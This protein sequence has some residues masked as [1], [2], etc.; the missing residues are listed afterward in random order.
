MKK[1]IV[2]VIIPVFN[3]EDSIAKCVDSVLNQNLLNYVILINDGSQDS[4]KI[5]LT[6]YQKKYEQIKLINLEYNKGLVN[7]LNIGIE[8]STAPFLARLDADDSM[9]PNRL[10]KQYNFLIKNN[11]DLIGGQIIG[12]QSG[13]VYKTYSGKRKNINKVDLFFSSC[14]FHPT[15]F[16]KSEVFNL[17]YQT[18]MP[19]EDVDFLYR[20]VQNGYRLRN[21][22]EPVTIWNETDERK[23]TITNKYSH[24]CLAY[25]IRLNYIFYKRVKVTNSRLLE[26]KQYLNKN[27][28]LYLPF[29]A[30]DYLRILLLKTFFN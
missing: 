11:L 26:I 20:A 15:W 4:T 8:N 6:E 5:I 21:I 7:A 3:A 10:K 27:K 13:K 25:I 17:K 18:M 9:T 28:L 24:L 16:G 14:L 19:V 30:L 2:D 29:K 12:E 1:K 22:L 23:I